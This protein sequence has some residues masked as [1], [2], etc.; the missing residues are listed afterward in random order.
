MS[1]QPGLLVVNRMELMRIAERAGRI[2]DR[3][4]ALAISAEEVFRRYRGLDGVAW[5]TEGHPPLR[6]DG[7]AEPSQLAAIEDYARKLPSPHENDIILLVQPGTSGESTQ[8]LGWR[9]IGFDVGY[10]ES[11][12]SHFSVVLNEVIWGTIDELRSFADKLNEY[13]LLNNVG[14]AEA[15]VRRHV[16]L[17]SE[18]SD[19]EQG[20]VEPLAIYVPEDG[21]H[22][23]KVARRE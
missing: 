23:A 4:P 17:A 6:D 14:D 13:L 1:G 22:A 5:S 11:A 7:L 2:M 15:L 18:G 8:R 19:V 9:L 21:D 20:E 3:E 12:W 16:A 10:Y